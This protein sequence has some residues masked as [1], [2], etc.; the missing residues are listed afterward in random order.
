MVLMVLDH[1]R[2]F[3]H[4][5]DAR[6]LDLTSTTPLLFVTRWMTH[7]CAPAFVFFA[8]VAA[9]LHAR[10]RPPAESARFLLTRGLFLVLL[11]ISVIRLLWVPDP[12]YRFTLLQVIWAIG[13]SMVL[14]AALTRL[15]RSA[16]LG[17]GVLCVV[18]HNALDGVHASQLGSL[19]PLWN[20]VHERGLVRFASGQAVLVSYP[21][22]PWVGVM[23]LG[24]AA[25]PLVEL[26]LA[27]RR[28]VFLGLGAAVTLAFVALR[29]LNGYGDPHPWAPQP[30]RLFTLF[31]FLS[32]EKYP[33]SLDYLLMTL[34]PIFVGFALAS[35]GSRES[36]VFTTFGKAPLVFYVAHLFLLRTA[37]LGFMIAPLGVPGS[38]TGPRGSGS[39]A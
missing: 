21:L 27:Q 32:C 37:S 20:V 16:V 4:R 36:S 38:F 7:Y 13:W 28:R 11:E 18:G 39:S 29:G 2:D 34:G 10:R 17:F 3:W 23:A 25:G 26:P 15:P 6:P 5:S 8:G 22:V 1:A 19:A 31:A 35:S 12:F 24:Y 30:T 14:L 9:H 33:P